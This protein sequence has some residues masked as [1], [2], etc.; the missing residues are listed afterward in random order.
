MPIVVYHERVVQSH[1]EAT[2]PAVLLVNEAPGP[3]E[4]ISGIPSFGQQGA[5][6]FHSLRAAGI[7]W[8]SAR[9]RFVWP[10]NGDSDQSKRHGLKAAF[11]A[12]RAKYITCTNAF[13]RW[14]RPSGK[15][16]GFCAPLDSDVLSPDNLDRLKSEIAPS[17]RAI[18][19][20]GRSA[21]LACVG[22]VLRAPASQELTELTTAELASLNERLGASFKRGWYMGHTRRWSSHGPKTTSTLKRVASF[23]GWGLVPNAG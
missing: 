15:P 8:A 17:H 5:N 19:V 13:S 11:L 6:I 3:S 22:A 20:C 16:K 1:G 7:S 4:A 10:R 18:L 14:P 2:G 23:V 12:D 9:E 21:Y